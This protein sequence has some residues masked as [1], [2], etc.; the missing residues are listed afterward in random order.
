MLPGRLRLSTERGVDAPLE[1]AEN[2]D[3]GDAEDLSNLLRMSLC[4]PELETRRTT[5]LRP[6][7]VLRSGILAARRPDRER[8][9]SIDRSG[10]GS[11]E[12]RTRTET[13]KI[14]TPNSPRR[15]ASP[16]RAQ[17]PSFLFFLPPLS[18]P[19]Y[20][21]AACPL[22]HPLH[23]S[24]F[25]PIRISVRVCSHVDYERGCAPGREPGGRKTR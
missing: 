23:P 11:A 4:A 20:L 15:L 16:R 24:P 19:R 22:V 2:G 17:P 13:N 14:C 1:D 7:V 5:G 10:F 25:T 12:S 9:R 18:T 6:G 8:D 3:D 21:L